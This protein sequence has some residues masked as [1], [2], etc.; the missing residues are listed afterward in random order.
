MRIRKK[1]KTKLQI[2]KD[3]TQNAIHEVNTQINTLGGYT[4]GLHEALT[5]IQYTFDKIRNVPSEQIIQYEELKKIRL[6]C[7]KGRNII[8]KRK[9]IENYAKYDYN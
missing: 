5:E 9:C 3:N 1:N 7:E 4:K 6:N 8:C 2:A